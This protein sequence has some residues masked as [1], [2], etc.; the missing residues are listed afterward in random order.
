MS[1]STQ[2]LISL[3]VPCYNEQE[4]IGLCFARIQAAVTPLSSTYK[5]EIIFINDGSRD[6]TLTLLQSLKSDVATIHVINLSRNFGKESAMTAGLDLAKG[7]AVIILD[8]DLQDP[9]ELI[10]DLIEIWNKE[11]ADVV[12]G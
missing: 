6:N 7:D 10:K 4:V 5:F 2:P 8:A 12:Y 11:S 9:P 1:E 3:I